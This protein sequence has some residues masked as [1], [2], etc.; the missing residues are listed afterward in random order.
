MSFEPLAVFRQSRSRLPIRYRVRLEKKICRLSLMFSAALLQQ[1]K[2]EPKYWRLDLDIKAK[3][4]RLTALI[5]DDGHGS[6]RQTPGHEKPTVIFSWA[7]P[8]GQRTC[9]PDKGAVLALTNHAVTSLG[10]EF[11]LP[12]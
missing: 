7:L 11:D 9:F 4:A 8:E 12:A 1:V 10:I 6:T 5:Q 3:R 2:G